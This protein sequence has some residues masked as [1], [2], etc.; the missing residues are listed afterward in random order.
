VAAPVPLPTHT[1]R[2][3]DNVTAST[4]AVSALLEHRGWKNASGVAQA[5]GILDRFHIMRGGH[6]RLTE[7]PSAGLMTVTITAFTADV[8]R[9]NLWVTDEISGREADFCDALDRW[10]AETTFAPGAVELLHETLRGQNFTTF[11][12]YPT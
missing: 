4:E 11:T 7:N 8:G 3:E 12:D 1:S 9:A 6:I 2:D 10:R 5:L